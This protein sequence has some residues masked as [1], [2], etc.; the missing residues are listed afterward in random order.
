MKK[1]AI[2]KVGL[3]CICCVVFFLAESGCG[4]QTATPMLEKIS[5]SLY[6]V[7]DACN[8][9]LVKRGDRALLIDS[10]DAHV[11]ELMHAQG[12]RSLDWVLHT[13]AHR[14]Q[15]QGTPRLV[16]AG[17]RVAVPEKEERFFIDA[18]GFWNDFQLFYLFICK[19]HL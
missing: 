17:V 16:E 19:R 13:H 3:T 18:T 2:I 1:P 6:L 10:G 15:C 7:R 9:Y 14:D 12:I 8:V 4:R 5:E 11:L